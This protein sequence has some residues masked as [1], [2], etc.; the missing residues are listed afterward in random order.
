MDIL[1]VLESIAR[2]LPELPAQSV[3]DQLVTFDALLNVTPAEQRPAAAQLLTDAA[4]AAAVPDLRDRLLQAA[5][6]VIAGSPCA[7]TPDGLTAAQAAAAQTVTQAE[8]EE[9]I[10]RNPLPPPPAESPVTEEDEDE[11]NDEEE[12][13]DYRE[14]APSPLPHLPVRHFFPGL[15]VRIGRDFTDAQ[16]RSL[17]TGDLHKLISL[18]A[19]KSGYLLNLIVRTVRLNSTG[20]AEIIGNADNAWFQPV[21]SIDCLE[22]LCEA[23]TDALDTAEADEAFDDGDSEPIEDLRSDLEDCAAW[24]SRSAASESTPRCQSAAAAAGLFGQDHPI[25]VWAHLLFAA[26]Q[27]AGPR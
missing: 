25:A 14:A 1:P 4:R 17:C 13:D 22:A 10:A 24:L 5:A 11:D 15:V 7:L 27:S 18:E 20:Q 2:L 26:I 12:S 8:W 19:G 16:G 23:L 21:P 9:R 3:E 6:A